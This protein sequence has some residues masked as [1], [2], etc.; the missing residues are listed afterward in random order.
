MAIV[1][2]RGRVFGRWN[3]LDLAVLVLL[4]GLIPL[5]Y[6]AFVL[7][8]DRPPQLLSVEP[9]QIAQTD[10]FTL[11]VKGLNFRPYMRVSIGTQQG[12]EFLFKST[13]EADVPFTSVPPG[14][15][16]V[17]LFDQAQERFRLRQVVTVSPS[18]LP[19]TQIVAIGAF[20]NLDAATAAKLQAGTTLP[21]GGEILAVGKPIPDLTDLYAGS[22]VVGVTLPN[23]LRV[24]AV[25]RFSCHILEQGGTPYCSINQV[26]IAPKNIVRVATPAGD[27][28]FQVQRARS[29]HPLQAV[30]VTLRAVGP[31]SLLSK[32]R[33]GDADTGGIDNDVEVIARVTSVGAV[34][35]LGPASAEADVTLSAN[36]QRVND[37]WLYDSAPLRV[38]G[39][40]H[41]KTKGY[42]VNTVVTDIV[43][44]RQ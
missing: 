2:E 26:T 36:L 41:F 32:I 17:V 39:Q 9:T 8:R 19:S 6:A 1:D 16:D 28:P 13:E 24:P 3:L 31:S 4:L 12:R 43:E 35:V 34:R 27:V 37:V 25:A 5:G 21:A 33:T 15:Y 44:S 14:T 10:T 42:E 40:L 22:K 30:T 20:V 29:P 38:G 23:A 18:N 11:H 7:F